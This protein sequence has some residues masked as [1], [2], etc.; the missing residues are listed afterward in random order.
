MSFMELA[1]NRQSDRTFSTQEV[2]QRP[3]EMRAGCS[4]GTFCLQFSTM[5]VYHH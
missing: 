1:N 3:A 2:N 5:E 4:I